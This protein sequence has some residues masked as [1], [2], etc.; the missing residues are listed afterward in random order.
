MT[1]LWFLRTGV[2]GPLLMAPGA[3]STFVKTTHH[4]YILDFI[5]YGCLSP[6]RSGCFVLIMPSAPAVQPPCLC[7]H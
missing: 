4:G 2:G 3:T 6:Q 7:A 1:K 5:V